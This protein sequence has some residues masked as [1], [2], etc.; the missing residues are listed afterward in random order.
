MVE[1]RVTCREG[2]VL[3]KCVDYFICSS[4]MLCSV[5]CLDV[6]DYCSMLSDAYNAVRLELNFE[7][8]NFERNGSNY[9]CQVMGPR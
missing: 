6:F 4:N 9:T 7:G 5:L 8:I 2:N 3:V 1:Q